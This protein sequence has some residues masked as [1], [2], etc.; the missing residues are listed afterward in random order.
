MHFTQLTKKMWLFLE[1]ICHIFVS[2]KNL[3][4]V[5]KYDGVRV[6]IELLFL[7]KMR[8]QNP[9]FTLSFSDTF[10]HVEAWQVSFDFFVHFTSSSSSSRAQRC[11]AIIGCN[12]PTVEKK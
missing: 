3:Q 2:D 9:P 10:S 5:C 7:K 8:T 4:N 12:Q 11:L 1:D 6:L